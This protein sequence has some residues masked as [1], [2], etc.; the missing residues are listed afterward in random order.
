MRGLIGRRHQTASGF[1]QRGA[2]P[3]RGACLV[4]RV[5]PSFSPF[6]GRAEALVKGGQRHVHHFSARQTSFSACICRSIFRD[7]RF[8]KRGSETSP[9]IVA[10]GRPSPLTFCFFLSS[11]AAFRSLRTRSLP[12]LLALS[13]H[14]KLLAA[15][16]LTPSSS[17]GPRYMSDCAPCNHDMEIVTPTN[18]PHSDPL[19]M[20]NSHF[21]PNGRPRTSRPNTHRHRSNSFPIVEA[22]G[23]STPEAQ[24]ILA[25]GRAAVRRRRARVRPNRSVDDEEAIVYEPRNHLKYLES[26]VDWPTNDPVSPDARSCHARIPSNTTDRSTSTIVPVSA[27]GGSRNNASAVSP[28]LGNYSANLAQFIKAQLKSI[29]TYHSERDSVSPLSPQSCPDFSFPA[30]TPSPLPSSPVRR[31]AQAPKA[32]EIPPVRPPARSA[33]SAWSSTDDDSDDEES[34]PDLEQSV[35]A[36]ESGRSP[37]T[38]SVLGY[39]GAQGNASFLFSSTPIEEGNDPDTATAST[40]PNRNTLPGSASEPQADADYPSSDFSRPRLSASSVPSYSSSS[41]SASASSYF[42]C[43]RPFTLAPELKD[44]IIAALTPPHPQPKMIS[45][46]SPWEGGAIA[47]VHDLWIESQQRIRVDGMSFDMVR[48]FVPPTQA[49]TPC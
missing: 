33:F 39:Y 25:E 32:I 35:K 12:V 30:R 44:R 2:T 40:F 13:L 17:T 37:Y 45:A 21:T 47:N 46:V 18:P 8:P 3:A 48:D 1:R 26:R 23:C 49:R 27:D 11:L 29:P 15:P 6:Q 31:P 24:L 16:D 36:A 41:A 42:D 20:D 38:P 10:L 5:R 34:L 9:L 14:Q 19:E 7:S 43:K 4:K 28:L 22:L